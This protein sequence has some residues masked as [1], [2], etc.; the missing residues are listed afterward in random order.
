MV[1]C[2]IG[3]KGR[4]LPQQLFGN[5]SMVDKHINDV[6]VP[7]VDGVLA[8]KDVIRCGGDEC[9]PR[10]GSGHSAIW[11]LFHGDMMA[12]TTVRFRPS[13]FGSKVLV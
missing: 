1:L 6:L 7:R 11:N 3:K 9:C 12:H 4:G 8:Y 2:R 5:H 10:G 13:Y